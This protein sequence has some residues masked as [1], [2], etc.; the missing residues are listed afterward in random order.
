[1]Y[2]M[3]I[4]L[5]EA[6]T[7]E[8]IS[9]VIAPIDLSQIAVI[10]TAWIAQLGISSGAYYFMCKSDHAKEIPAQM[11]KDLPKDMREK[12]SDPTEIIVAAIT[13]K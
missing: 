11:I 6:G 3:S 13:T 9:G 10:L 1:M 5:I 4:D 8:N 7:P 2:V 12:I